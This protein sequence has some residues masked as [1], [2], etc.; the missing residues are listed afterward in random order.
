MIF[1]E[2]KLKDFQE[3]AIKALASDDDLFDSLVLKGGNAIDL[4]LKNSDQCY[5]RVSQDLD[6]S[7]RQESELFTPI[8]K[9]Q[10]KLHNSYVAW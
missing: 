5:E 2:N 8:S 7:I 6:Y 1:D 10:E 4:L 3:L 9:A